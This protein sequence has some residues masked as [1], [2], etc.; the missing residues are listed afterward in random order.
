MHSPLQYDTE[1]V[2]RDPP[3]VSHVLWVLLVTSASV[4]YP[5]M[6]YHAMAPFACIQVECTNCGYENSTLQDA[7]GMVYETK[8]IPFWVFDMTMVCYTG[9]H[10]RLAWSVGVL[11][12]L[13]VA[14]L[15]P[16]F[17]FLQLLR[18]RRRFHK[19]AVQQYLLWL[20]HPYRKRF[21]YWEV[22]RM[23]STFCYVAINVL[24]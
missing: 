1:G 6:T 17:V 8:K 20:Y 16:I 10:A 7:G 3:S 2:V 4:V 5:Y 24:G 9:A 14:I 22:L 23:F 18:Y 11:M 12:T 19:V 13:F 15:T 21:W